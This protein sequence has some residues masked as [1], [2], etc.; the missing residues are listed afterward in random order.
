MQPGG[1]L[2]SSVS[3]Q[4]AAMCQYDMDIRCANSTTNKH[5]TMQSLI[6]SQCQL[7]QQQ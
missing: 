3:H 1:R 6:N 2:P 4:V 5:Y 7:Q